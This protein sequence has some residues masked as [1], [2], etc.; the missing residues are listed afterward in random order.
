MSELNQ[1]DVSLVSDLK[2]APQK[3]NLAHPWALADVLHWLAVYFSICSS[4][5][6]TNIGLAESVDFI[7]LL[8]TLTLPNNI[9]SLELSPAQLGLLTPSSSCP[10]SGQDRSSILR[11]LFFNN[12]VRGIIDLI[13]APEDERTKP[14]GRQS[15]FRFESDQTHI[16]ISDFTYFF[17]IYLSLYLYPSHPWT[18]HSNSQPYNHASG[19]HSKVL[20]TLGTAC[21][22]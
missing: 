6:V 21:I 22:I 5:G 8:M 2:N 15:G 4:K 1:M 12:D 10:Y 13:L 18:S 9:S 19:F 3:I 11:E 16:Y 14:D 7:S 17:F 20:R